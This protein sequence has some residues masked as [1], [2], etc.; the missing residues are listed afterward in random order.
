M[1][2]MTP[3]TYTRQ[4]SVSR[5]GLGEDGCW[6]GMMGRIYVFHCPSSCLPSCPFIAPL[7]TPL[8]SACPQNTRI[9][10]HPARAI[11][12]SLCVL[13][14]SCGFKCHLHTGNT[15]NRYLL[16]RSLSSELHIWT[17]NCPL[18]GSTFMSQKHLKH[19]TPETEL[20]IFPQTSPFPDFPS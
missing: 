11:F 7:L 10:Q 14:Q 19:N 8:P 15:P 17:S 20:F 18:D 5:G 13:P 1:K 9:P 4:S 3:K 12:S 6:V 2:G 16:P